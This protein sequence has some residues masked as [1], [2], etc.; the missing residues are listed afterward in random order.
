MT[1]TFGLLTLAPP[2]AS[3][4]TSLARWANDGSLPATVH[5]CVS[6]AEVRARL[7]AGRRWSAL[8]VDAASPE[9]DRDLL[10]RCRSASVAVVLVGK[11]APHEG[12]PCLAPPLDRA[13]LLSVL[14][15][16][17]TTTGDPGRLALHPSTPPPPAAAGAVLAVT[18]PGGTGASVTAMALAQA[19][20]ASGP[21]LLADLC[22]RADL[23]ML[24]DAPDVVPG[25]LELVEA[26]RRGAV[27]PE[28]IDALTWHSVER[29]YHLLLGLRRPSD[30]TAL[31]A[32]AVAAAV[33]SLERRWGRV[34]ADIDPDCEG[35]RETGSIE[36]EERHLLSREVLARAALA[37][38]VTTPDLRG[39]HSAG[40][41][42]RE[43]TEE[44]VPAERVQVVVTR[45]PRSA[46]RRAAVTRAVAEVAS[47]GTRP[48]LA[49]P[50]L[51]LRERPGLDTCLVEGT[52]LPGAH[53][54]PLA[55][56]VEARLGT[57]GPRARASLAV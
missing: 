15:A 4:A 55:A 14:E 50:P 23:A 18:G 54:A 57:L 43:L 26:H 5:K 32:R 56:L 21:V 7:G 8:V 45:A 24:H 16:H 48:L 6:A 13:E 39:I 37:L 1:R 27:A 20:A 12:L 33:D 22:R 2:A 10:A 28:A 29:G 34:V 38:V 41:L 49:T 35:E 25:L 3:W 31:R 19:L 9:L 53:G 17:A 11:S 36:V 47:R 42:V 44:L 40:R 51:H 52:P 46:R 30:W